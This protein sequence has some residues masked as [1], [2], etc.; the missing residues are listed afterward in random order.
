MNVPAELALATQRLGHERE[1]FHGVVWAA[2]NPGTEKQS[3]D[4]VAFVELERKPDNLID[5]KPGPW[6]RTG[7][8]IHAELAIVNA[9]IGQQDLQ[10]GHATPVGRVAVADPGPRA[11]A[12]PVLLP[13]PPPPLRFAPLLAQE[14]SY[15]AASASTSSFCY[16]CMRD[17]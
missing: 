1:L 17:H 14:A 3:F 2:D 15:F 6:R 8:S 16:I 7:N 10:Q 11:V 12:Q 9:V 13:N 5:C 4:V